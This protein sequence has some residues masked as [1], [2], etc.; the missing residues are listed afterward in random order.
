MIY[1]ISINYVKSWSLW[2]CVREILQNAID[3]SSLLDVC[4]EDGKLHVTNGGTFSKRMLLLGAT[5][6][7]ERLEA[8]GQFGEGLKLA[9]LVAARLNRKMIITSGQHTYTPRI[10]HSKK[11]DD[12][13]LDLK[14]KQISEPTNTTTVVIDMTEEEWYDIYGKKWI[15]DLEYGKI[16]GIDP[17]KVYVSG[18]YISQFKDLEYSYNF[19]PSQLELNRDRDIPSM[20]SVQLA[21]SEVLSAEEILNAAEAGKSDVSQYAVM[22]DKQRTIANHWVSKYGEDCVPIGVDEQDTIKAENSRIVPGWI[23]RAI[24]SIKNFI[25]NTDTTPIERLKEWRLRNMKYLSDAASDELRGIVEEL[26]ITK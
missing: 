19:K 26:C 1:P 4:H 14:I 25:F 7:D 17:G 2:E 9:M 24:R 23:A 22:S 20:F 18:L 3:A 5:D 10:I 21:A 6:K 15:G 8:V 11:F 16:E 13:I 12:D